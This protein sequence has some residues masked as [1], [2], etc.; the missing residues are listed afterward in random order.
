VLGHGGGQ[1]GEVLGVGQ[2]QEQPGV[3][4]ARIIARAD[5]AGQPCR[6]LGLAPDV[7][8]NQQIAVGN[9]KRFTPA[10]RH[11][12]WLQNQGIRALPYMPGKNWVLSLATK[13][14][15]EAANAITLPSPTAGE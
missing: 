10:S 7:E 4:R 14:V 9:A 2:P 6:E 11:Q 15:K 3:P 13:G 1:A 5:P 8:R 12:I